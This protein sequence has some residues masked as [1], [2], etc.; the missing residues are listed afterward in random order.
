[1]FFLP[2]P[3]TNTAE[4]LDGVTQTLPGELSSP[5]LYVNVNGQSTSLKLCG[6]VLYMLKL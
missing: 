2:K 1:M 4:T 3:H 5:E 6:I